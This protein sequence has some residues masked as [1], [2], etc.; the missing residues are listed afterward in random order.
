M[1]GNVREWCADPWHDN[2]A[3]APQDAKVWDE[4]GNNL[5][6]VLRG[7]SWNYDPWNCRVASRFNSNPDFRFI[8]NGFRVARDH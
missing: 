8:N 5:Y 2:Y 7:G 4:G 1:S 3:N 6:R